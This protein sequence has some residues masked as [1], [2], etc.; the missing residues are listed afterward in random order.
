MLSCVPICAVYMLKKLH[1][2]LRPAGIRLY[3][4]GRGAL[5][6]LNWNIPLEY[7]SHFQ[8]ANEEE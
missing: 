5:E 4:A 6:M 8:V 2:E 1:N 3:A 7:V